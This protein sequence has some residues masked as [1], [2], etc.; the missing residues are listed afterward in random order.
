MHTFL[1]VLSPF[2][3]IFSKK[4]NWIKNQSDGRKKIHESNYSFISY[5]NFWSREKQQWKM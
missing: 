2:I 1:Y 4:K 3:Y 5:F